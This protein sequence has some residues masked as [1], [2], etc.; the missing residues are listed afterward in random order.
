MKI[1]TINQTLLKEYQNDPEV[2]RKTARPCVLIIRL[3]YKG[4]NR[5][6]AIPLRSNT[7]IDVLIKIL[8]YNSCCRVSRGSSHDSSSINSR[9]SPRREDASLRIL[10]GSFSTDCRNVC[11]RYSE[12]P[13]GRFQRV[14][15]V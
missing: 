11:V 7:R 6:F 14:C 13:A 9:G 4:V 8:P 2:L 10:S 12:V 5:S 15:A 1:V 3:K